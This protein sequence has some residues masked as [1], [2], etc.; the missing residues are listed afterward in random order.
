[1]RWI[2]AKPKIPEQKPLMPKKDIKKIFT[3]KIYFC[4][5][6]PRAHIRTQTF[7]IPERR[8]KRPLGRYKLSRN[9]L[10]R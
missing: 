2:D 7:S 10:T 8:N 3:N 9:S 5:F 1:M 4:P 6:S